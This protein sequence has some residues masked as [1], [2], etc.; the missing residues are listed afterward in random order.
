MEGGGRRR[1]R[2]KNMEKWSE[3][4]GRK[5]PGWKLN[6]DTPPYADDN[7]RSQNIQRLREQ[8]GLLAHTY[9]Y[10]HV[11]L[12]FNICYVI[13]TKVSSTQKPKLCHCSKGL[14]G[15]SAFRFKDKR[16]LE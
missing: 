16:G 14:K 4:N 5:S 3:R 10:I 9:R 1:E 2:K 8:A 13:L 6:G 7:P 11:Q 12:E 15:T